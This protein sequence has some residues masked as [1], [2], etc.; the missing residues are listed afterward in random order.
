MLSLAHQAFPLALTP[1][2]SHLNGGV[3]LT[4]SLVVRLGLGACVGYGEVGCPANSGY[5]AASLLVLLQ[6]RAPSI[7]RY[8]L[9]DPHRFWHFLEHLL[10]GDSAL[11]AALDMAGWDLYAHLRRLPLHKALG[12]PLKQAPKTS[13]P[14]WSLDDQALQNHLR[15]SLANSFKITFKEPAA[16]DWLRR[17]RQATGKPIRVEAKESLQFDDT[18][19]L[20]PELIALGV[21][22]LEQPLPREQRAEM[23]EIK[24][25]SKLLLLADESCVSE[26][27]IELC[28]RQFHGIHVKLAKCG[29]LTPALNM[30]QKAGRHDLKVMIGSEAESSLGVATLC[31]LAPFAD[32]LDAEA[33]FRLREDLAKGLSWVDGRPLLSDAPGNGVQYFGQPFAK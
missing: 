32:F 2:F 17:V 28:A 22:L 3:T 23:E 29:G 1:T 15:G 31:Q 24:A 7:T 27:D 12:A 26:T 18:L 33:F 5:S 25:K 9:T 10:P 6:T 21:E 11:V 16:I 13:I 4:D 20:I 30:I 14:V 8:A 19:R